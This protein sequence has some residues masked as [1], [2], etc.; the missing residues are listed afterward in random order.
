MYCTN[1]CGYG[2]IT[3]DKR[4]KPICGEEKNMKE[5]QNEINKR[6][7]DFLNERWYIANMKD[8]RPQDMSYYNGALKALEFAGY[9]WRRDKE[10]EHRVFKSR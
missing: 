8:L 7:E 6:I 1:V 10:G 9:D 2:I 5:K 4:N 3:I